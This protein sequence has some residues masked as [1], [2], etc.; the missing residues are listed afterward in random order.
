MNTLFSPKRREH[1]NLILYGE[2]GKKMLPPPAPS[3][4]SLP[5]FFSKT[6]DL[7]TVHFNFYRYDSLR[8]IYVDSLGFK[9]LQEIFCRGHHLLR[10][11]FV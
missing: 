5:T 10:M 7:N 9:L 3:Q 4:F 6:F 1:A 8:S 2:G 11:Q